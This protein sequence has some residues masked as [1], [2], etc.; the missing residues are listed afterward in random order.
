MRLNPTVCSYWKLKGMLILAV[1]V[2]L[3]SFPLLFLPGLSGLLAVSVILLIGTTLI[4]LWSDLFYDRYLYMIGD[5]GV[6]INRGI[7]FKS[8]RTIPYERI[9]HISVTRGPLEILFGIS[10]L[11]I[12]T[13]GTGSMGSSALQPVT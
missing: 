9:Q 4:F 12:F 1:F 11:N 13:A 3:F 7:W 6:Y 10:D 5:D 2:F 8:N